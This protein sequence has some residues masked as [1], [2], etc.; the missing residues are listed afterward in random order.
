MISRKNKAILNRYL[1]K[2]K[3]IPR[4]TKCCAMPEREAGIVE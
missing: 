1:K 4:A 3:V 2:M